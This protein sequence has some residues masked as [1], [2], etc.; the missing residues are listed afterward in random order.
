VKRSSSTSGSLGPQL[1]FGA[2]QV[3]S[4]ELLLAQRH[5]EEETVYHFIA[6][7]T[8][9]V[10]RQLIAGSVRKG[11]IPRE[12]AS[13][14]ILHGETRVYM[15][16]GPE[17]VKW[18]LTHREE[19]FLRVSLYLHSEIRSTVR[20]C[21]QNWEHVEL[22]DLSVE[23][24]KP[25]IA[26]LLYP[27][28]YGHVRMAAQLQV[29]QARKTPNHSM[30]RFVWNNAEA[31]G[32]VLKVCDMTYSA[33]GPDLMRTCV[34]NCTET[35]GWMVER[36]VDDITAQVSSEFQNLLQRQEFYN[37]RAHSFV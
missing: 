15:E 5:N 20:T 13:G 19:Q 2:E 30:Q 12:A 16:H 34:A 21:L 9:S 1:Q 14:L 18:A 10:V 6:A 25:E 36:F 26:E 33:I 28:I 32:W 37:P 11:M 27:I 8:N 22:L 24:P 31:E 35:F 17:L 23:L 3:Q 7:Q 4:P 29:N